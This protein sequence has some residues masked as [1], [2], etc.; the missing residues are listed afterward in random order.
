[1]RSRFILKS[2]LFISLFLVF[3]RIIIPAGLIG[4]KYML[5]AISY[6]IT[7]G[8]YLVFGD[9]HT[10]FSVTS[11]FFD[12]AGVNL[13]NYSRGGH[14]AVF[15]HL[16]YR[17][18]RK[19]H[20]PPE[21]VVISCPFFLFNSD[22][23]E[24]SIF[25]LLSPEEFSTYAF[26]R[27]FELNL[28]LLVFREILSEL[29]FLLPKV[30]DIGPYYVSNVGYMYG[31]NPGLRESSVVEEYSDRTGIRMKDYI[32]DGYTKN[33]RGNRRNVES[34]R[35]LLD[36]L[37]KD[38]VHVFLLETPEYIG[39]LKTVSGRDQFYREIQEEINSRN[40]VTFLKQTV[41]SSI[42]HEYIPDFYDGGPGNV[43]SHLSY[44]GSMKFSAELLD[45]I[46]EHIR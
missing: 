10:A 7:E 36:T 9:S 18:Y 27:S 38:G 28:N 4:S 30:T 34:F 22:S 5:K 33:V 21:A 17:E 43:N 40:N 23:N 31:Y 24:L 44:Q 46:R 25:Q 8:D 3:D 42:D 6:E 15:N 13:V 16:L 2:I 32:D 35:M 41:F 37:D 11:D 20:P 14:Y 45:M 26:S 39:T 1:M 19:N 29:P 12:S